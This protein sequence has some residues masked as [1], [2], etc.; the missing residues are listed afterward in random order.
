MKNLITICLLVATAFTT[1]AQEMNFEETVKYINEKMI[2]CNDFFGETIIAK[3]DGTISWCK[4][5]PKY[6]VNLLDLF[7][8]DTYNNGKS[9]TKEFSQGI[10][11][12]TTYGI[13]EFTISSSERIRFGEF[14]VE[15][16]QKRVYNAL[17]HLRSLCS[18][19]KD[20]FD[21]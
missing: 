20:P 19:A 3:K 5:F 9:F 16:E 7:E 4:Q 18:K 21:K 8:E 17:I 13:I 15:A 11:R 1:N 10:R 12:G 2:C 6:T 14:K